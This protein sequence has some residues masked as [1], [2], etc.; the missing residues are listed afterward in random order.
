MYTTGL[1][2]AHY[3]RGV[4]TSWNTGVFRL[5][6]SIHDS[7]SLCRHTP[8][9]FWSAQG[10]CGERVSVVNTALG[11]TTGGVYKD[12]WVLKPTVYILQKNSERPLTLGI[13][14]RFGS[15]I[16]PVLGLVHVDILQQLS[17]PSEVC[18]ANKR[19]WC[20]QALGYTTGG[21]YKDMCL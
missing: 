13:P 12:M 4:Q 17:G 2:V 20:V 11:Y 16:A 15:T 9:V 10:V 18:A 19:R 6:D 7:P 14:D 21:V 3:F 5:R 8:T 1:H